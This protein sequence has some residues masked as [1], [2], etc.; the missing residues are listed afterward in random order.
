MQ[1]TVVVLHLL[2]VLYSLLSI[3][4]VNFFPLNMV[5]SNFATMLE[6]GCS[7]FSM[8]LQLFLLFCIFFFASLLHF[9]DALMASRKKALHQ[10]F[11]QS[12]WFSDCMFFLSQRTPF[13]LL[14]NAASAILPIHSTYKHTHP[15]HYPENLCTQDIYFHFIWWH[16]TTTLLKCSCSIKKSQSRNWFYP[17]RPGFFFSSNRIKIVLLFLDEL[18]LSKREK[19]DNL[20]HRVRK[21]GVGKPNEQSSVLSVQC[22]LHKDSFS[23]CP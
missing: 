3:K 21:A 11:H 19:S 10:H 20:A 22:W 8:W 6:S 4:A 16:V 14:V 9:A 7:L 23:L 13:A 12:L 1:P 17:A 15:C 5:M 18:Q 2:A